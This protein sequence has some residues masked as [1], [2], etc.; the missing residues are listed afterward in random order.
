MSGLMIGLTID[1]SSSMKH[2]PFNRQVRQVD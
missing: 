2:G 1:R